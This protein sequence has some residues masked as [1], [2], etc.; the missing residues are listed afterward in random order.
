MAKLSKLAPK[1]IF[2]KV[3][4]TLRGNVGAELEAMIE[5]CKPDYVF[6]APTFLPNK[7]IVEQGIL[8]VNGQPIGETEFAK[9]E[10]DPVIHS[11]ISDHVGK[12][13]NGSMEVVPEHIWDKD[14][15]DI[16]NWL[17]ENK[18]TVLPF[19]SVMPVHLKH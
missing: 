9:N 19:S 16:R 4:S 18:E 8:Y 13:F 7:R 10:A 6:L 2:K 5:E 11:A 1:V 3:D 14:D 12:Q 17:K 15:A